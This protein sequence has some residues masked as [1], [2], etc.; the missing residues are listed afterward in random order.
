MKKPLLEDKPMIKSPS[1][2]QKQEHY[3]YSGMEG[4]LGGYAPVDCGIS[5]GTVPAE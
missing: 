4:R 1:N 5:L 3:T 2:A